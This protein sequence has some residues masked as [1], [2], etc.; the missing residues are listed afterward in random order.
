MSSIEF[1]VEGRPA[2]Q[3]S[4][5]ALGPGRMI[6]MSKYVKPWRAAVKAA[7][8]KAAADQGWRLLDEPCCLEVVFFMARP[9]RPKFESPGVVP[10]LSKL[11]R[12][13]EDAL[14]KVIWQDDSRVVY[15][16]SA[17]E[18]VRGDEVPGALIKVF[19]IAADDEVA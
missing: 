3:G 4:K 9:A 10:D 16:Q 12:S 11:V 8:T 6:E 15:T 5:R 17:K 18:Y 1:Y 13:T 7:A 14:T 2:P 19:T